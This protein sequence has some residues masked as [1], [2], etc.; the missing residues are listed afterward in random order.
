MVSVMAGGK[1]PITRAMPTLYS[2]TLCI[3]PADRWNALG[4][5][6]AAV[7]PKGV[8]LD[9]RQRESS[10]V[11]SSAGGRAQDVQRVR[12]AVWQWLLDRRRR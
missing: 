12:R 8:D 9:Y 7:L 2:E 3:A 6:H 4:A 5:L 10:F 1:R 11:V